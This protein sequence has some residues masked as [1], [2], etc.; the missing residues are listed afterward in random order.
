MPRARWW[1]LAGL[2]LVTATVVVLDA[3]GVIFDGEEMAA[4]PP[5]ALAFQDVAVVE[6]S[7]QPV[8]AVSTAPL[9]KPVRNELSRILTDEVLGPRV[10]A[11]VMGVTGEVLYA[12][13]PSRS[14]AP[15]STI[16][17]LTALSVLDAFDA[18]DRIETTVVEGARPGE[19]V[20]VGS[21]D[22]TLT[23]DQARRGDPPSASLTALA[24]RTARA[25]DDEELR[26][27]YDSSLFTGPSTSP[28]WE[29]TYV[30]SGVIAPVTALMVDQ[31]LVSD[32]SL[33]RY[34]EPDL[35]AAN[36]FVALLEDEGL[37]VRGEP[38]PVTS[39]PAATAVASVESPP[40]DS[41]VERMLR[42]SDN[43]LAE[44]LG[45]LAALE[46]G[47]PGSFE[48]SSAAIAAVAAAHGIDVDADLVHDA[49]GLS[50]DDRVTASAL[51]EAVTAAVT[52][53]SLRPVT[54][55]LPVAG[56]DGTLSDRYL[57]PPQSRA[58]GLVRAKTGTLTGISAEAGMTV[59][60]DGTLV[61]F[62]FVADRVPF[63][64]EAARDALDEAA[65]ALT[66]CG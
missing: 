57:R 31:G 42:E 45:R 55:G 35:A 53:P 13:D 14:V 48:G 32:T 11:V 5:P 50:R 34:P 19:V 22:A 40:I 61:Q 51:V 47:L 1:V 36:D 43:Q 20:L 29:P 62:A 3:T 10:S 4:P 8:D 65:A 26:V 52:E 6:A 21:G 46:S 27:S 12:Q 24:R 17:L 66:T 59:T 41:L 54:T 28:T 58:A 23:E 2:G 30:S 25:V 37:T 9:P 15:A 64:T 39:R 49:S 16:K 7:L 18:A 63:D 33:A 44:A 56:F 60:C 38:K